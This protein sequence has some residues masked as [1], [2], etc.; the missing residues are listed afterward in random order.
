MPAKR[1]RPPRQRRSRRAR[2]RISVSIQFDADIVAAF[3]STGPGWLKRIN[4]ALRTYLDT[5]R[6]GNLSFQP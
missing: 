2:R 4:T 6:P 3:R 5:H 1:P